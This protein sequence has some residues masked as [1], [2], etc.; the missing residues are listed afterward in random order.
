M[1]FGNIFE[2]M[3]K[4]EN[5]T[6]FFFKQAENPPDLY[7]DEI[8]QFVGRLLDKDNC[9]LCKK[10]YDTIEHIPRIMI[11]CGH[12]FCTPCLKK[13]YMYSSSHIGIAG[14]AAP[15]VSNQSNSSTPSTG[16]PSTIQF[17]RISSKRNQ[18]KLK[19]MEN[20]IPLKM[21]LSS[22]LENFNESKKRH[23]C[24]RTLKKSTKN[25]GCPSASSTMTEQNTFTARLTKY[26]L[27]QLGFWLQSLHRDRSPQERVLSN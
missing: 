26:S 3:K 5:P 2:L 9:P 20:N 8:E 14:C 10:E 11:H 24:A 16:F 4:L 27:T 12:T 21:L 6:T 19:K 13:F 23:T 22:S 18:K 17:L 25:L 15:C 7:R 1:I